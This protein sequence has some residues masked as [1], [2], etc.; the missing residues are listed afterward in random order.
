MIELYGKSLW[1]KRGLMINVYLT[2]RCNLNCPDC[3]V[4]ANRTPCPESTPAEWY[5][6][7]ERFPERIKEV[8]LSGGEPHL[9]PAF[10]EVANW[11]LEHGIHVSLATN[12]HNIRLNKD[13]AILRILPQYNFQISATCHQ[14]PAEF[15]T[16]VRCL[17]ALGYRVNVRE[18]LTQPGES[19]PGAVKLNWN[20]QE[21]LY[22]EKSGLN[23][24]PDRSI[25]VNAY[26][27]VKELQRRNYARIPVYSRSDILHAPAPDNIGG[28]RG[29]R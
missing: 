22:S 11:L 19:V 27:M 6:F 2:L 9:Y 18:L 14:D 28:R 16:A 10:P 25:H 24:A 7:F 3:C 5:E 23:I 21:W 17:R 8:S 15:M 26:H 12:L 4:Q 1:F 13:W 20:T 29:S